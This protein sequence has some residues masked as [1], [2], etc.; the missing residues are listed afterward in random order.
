MRLLISVDSVIPRT[1]T[2]YTVYTAAL[3]PVYDSVR[4]IGQR[5]TMH[6][7]VLCLV[8]EGVIRRTGVPYDVHD[9]VIRPT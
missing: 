2:C 6:G 5:S 1:G 7:E 4:Y 3:Y 8:Q 9:G